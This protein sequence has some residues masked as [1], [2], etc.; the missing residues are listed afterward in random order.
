[1]SVIVLVLLAAGVGNRVGQWWTTGVPLALGAT[2]TLTLTALGRGP[3]DSPI[4][5]VVVV[6][7]LAVAA[8][9]ALARR[10]AAPAL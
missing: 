5:F 3:G 7:T 9:V 1:M 10:P 8:G 4:A 6:C 2:W